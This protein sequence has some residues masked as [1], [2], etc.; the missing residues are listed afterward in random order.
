MPLKSTQNQYNFSVSKVIVRRI[1]SRLDPTA[2]IPQARGQVLY[3]RT[4]ELS[5][6]RKRH[7]RLTEAI[8][9]REL[10]NTLQL[11]EDV[12]YTGDTAI[13]VINELVRRVAK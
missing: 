7:K 8:R 11:L 6:Y 4:I 13:L 1:V 10:T 5:N 9:R 12:G 3:Y 2:I